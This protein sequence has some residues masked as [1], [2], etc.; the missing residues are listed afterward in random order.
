MGVAVPEAEGSVL[1]MAAHA[2]DGPIA[3]VKIVSV[4]PRNRDLPTHQALLVVFDALTGAPVAVMDGEHV[5]A[6]R[7]AAGSRLATRLLAVEG[8]SVLAVIGAGVQA[9]AHLRALLRERPFEEVRIAGRDRA[10]AARLG[11][12]VSEL[13][14]ARVVVAAGPEEALRGAHV[15]CATT[16]STVPVVRREWLSAGTHVNSVGWTPDGREVDAQTVR[17]ALVVVESREAALSPPPAGS[18]D[19]TWPIRDGI[20]GEDLVHAELGELVA[21]DRRGREDAEQLT[22][23]KSVGVAIEDDAAAALALRVAER[24]GLGTLVEL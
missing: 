15:V 23:Y 6:A 5:T 14:G 3:T 10:R 11:T 19:L 18:N 22:L 7:T 21:G 16:S 8:A 13:S 20:G 12:L 1:V 2:A 9:Q 17:D 24:D 4:F